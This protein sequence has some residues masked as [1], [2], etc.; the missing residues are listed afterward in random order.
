MGICWLV[1]GSRDAVARPLGGGVHQGSSLG[2]FKQTRT[3]HLS[4]ERSSRLRTSKVLG[5]LGP[6]DGVAVLSFE[7][8]WGTRCLWL[9]AVIQAEML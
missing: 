4:W 8:R 7:P 3:G 1:L 5:G 2:V 6:G 9:R